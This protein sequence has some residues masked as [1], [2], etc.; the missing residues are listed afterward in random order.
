M[1]DKEH[2]YIYIDGEP[3]EVSSAV[4]HVFYGMKDQENEQERKKR[5]N[6]VLSYDALDHDEQLGED[7]FED[8]RSATLDEL[9]IAA[10][11]R[12]RLHRAL[13]SL[14][15]SERELIEAIYLQDIPVSNYAAKIGWSI[16]GV[17][18]RRVKILSKLRKTMNLLGSF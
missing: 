10:E 18:K 14:P 2:Y 7:V 3:I 15:R 6:D 9:L 4:Y 17:N 5:R 1:A 11:V 8:M 12:E 13:L 16:S